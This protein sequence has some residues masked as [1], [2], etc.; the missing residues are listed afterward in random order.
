MVSDAGHQ[1]SDDLRRG[2]EGAEGQ[3]RELSGSSDVLFLN[4]MV[5]S[6]VF[7]LL[8]LLKL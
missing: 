3:T 5:T 6:W 2:R 7:M 4:G 8:S 1:D